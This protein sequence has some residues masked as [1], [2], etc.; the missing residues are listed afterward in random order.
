MFAVPSHSASLMAFKASSGTEAV[1]NDTMRA[2]D[3][4]L[5]SHR[6]DFRIIFIIYRIKAAAA[7]H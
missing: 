7:T 2:T 6:V 5:M 3:V 4:W 1:T